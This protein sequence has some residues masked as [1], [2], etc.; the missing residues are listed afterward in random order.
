MANARAIEAPRISGI[1]PTVSNPLRAAP[2][3]VASVAGFGTQ[4]KDCRSP[5]VKSV[6]IQILAARASRSSA[7]GKAMQNYSDAP[8]SQSHEAPPSTAR[9]WH[10]VQAFEAEH[11]VYEQ[12]THAPMP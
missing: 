8:A 3:P 5:F 7:G 11:P 6:P 4:A 10:V 2:C 1:V 12:P 9:Q